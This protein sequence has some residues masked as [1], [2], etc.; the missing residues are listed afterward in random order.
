MV[1]RF[2]GKEDG[3]GREDKRRYGMAAILSHPRGGGQP[4]SAPLL[5]KC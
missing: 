2:G 3:E 4:F 1:E 5:R